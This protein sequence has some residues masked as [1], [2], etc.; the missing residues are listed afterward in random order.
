[1]SPI[2]EPHHTPPIPVGRFVL[3]MVAHMC[4]AL[5]VI[6]ISLLLGMLGYRHY[7]QM[8]WTDA[9]VNSAMLLGGMGPVKTADLS[10]PGKLFAGLYALYA[11]LVFIAVMSIML[12]PVVHRVLHRFHWEEE[13]PR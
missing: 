12:A 9:F 1:M 11:G 5:V 2:Y 13:E 10:E 3:R 4:V 7:E 6:A 8:S